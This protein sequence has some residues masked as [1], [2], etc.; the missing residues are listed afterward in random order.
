MI[1]SIKYFQANSIVKKVIALVVF[2]LSFAFAQVSTSPADSLTSSTA[3][4]EAFSHGYISIEGGE[5]YPWGDLEDAVENTFYAGFGFR[6]SYWNNVDGI[7]N[8]N[9]SYFKPV[10]EDVPYDGVHQFT[11]RVG[12]DWHLAMIR[13]IILGGGFTCNWT[14]AD[15]DDDQ[16][17]NKLYRLP[18]GTLV[19]NETEFGWFAR[20]NVPLWNFEKMRVG[21]NFL[22]EEV[23]TLPERSNMLTAGL[24]IERRLW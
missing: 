17:K 7:V 15:L 20:I 5:V 8:F 13:P 14:R 16:K 12:L 1:M 19:D 3:A 24:Y 4:D 11:G 6:Y 21:F 2:T 10:P 23:W 9:Y 18:G 22:W